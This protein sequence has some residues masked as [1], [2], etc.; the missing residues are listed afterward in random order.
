MFFKKSKQIKEMSFNNEKLIDSNNL[1]KKQNNTLN[2]NIDNLKKQ[3]DELQNIQLKSQKEIEELKTEMKELEEKNEKIDKKFKDATEQLDKFKQLNNLLFN[4]PYLD[5]FIENKY[6]K[7]SESFSSKIPDVWVF[8]YNA[9]LEV[10]D[11]YTEESLIKRNNII[12]EII[13]LIKRF[14]CD[15]QREIFIENIFI[16]TKILSVKKKF[17]FNFESFYFFSKILEYFQKNTIIN[18]KLQE[19]IKIQLSICKPQTNQAII[20]ETAS[21]Q[22]D[23]SEE[24]IFKKTCWDILCLTTD[25]NT[26]YKLLDI[27]IDRCHDIIS[28]RGFMLIED[29]DEFVCM[30]RNYFINELISD[31][32][33]NKKDLLEHAIE[34]ICIMESYYA[35][36]ALHELYKLISYTINI[37]L[38]DKNRIDMI[39]NIISGNIILITDFISILDS[40]CSENSIL[41]NTNIESLFVHLA[42]KMSTSTDKEVY[43]KLG[44]SCPNYNESDKNKLL[45]IQNL[46]NNSNLSQSTK[47]KLLINLNSTIKAFDDILI[48]SKRDECRSTTFHLTEDHLNAIKWFFES[49]ATGE[50]LFSPKNLYHQRNK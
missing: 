49:I 41:E 11:Y 44:F 23:P 37:N 40:L 35:R 31:D 50:E 46:V 13:S 42:K 43:N 4:L 5:E 14:S 12:D 2:K 28:Y 36:N 1:L 30:Y 39:F 38:E 34:R 10:P 8:N 15:S 33:P 47:E 20:D 32:Y 18:S 21:Q 24:Y 25:I 27:I 48:E 9:T 3:I 16:K 7:L 17:D 6:H 22:F 19:I 26:Q 29:D 45:Q